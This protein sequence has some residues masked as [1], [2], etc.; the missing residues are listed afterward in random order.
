[1]SCRAQIVKRE[2]LLFGVVLL[3][4]SPFRMVLRFLIRF[5]WHWFLPS[6]FGSS[7]S[8]GVVLL[9]NFLL[10]GGAAF[11]LPPF[12]WCFG[13][14]L[15]Q[16]G[17][18]F[19]PPS[20]WW[21]NV[22]ELWIYW[23]KIINCSKRHKRRRREGGREGGAAPPEWRRARQH[24]PVRMRAQQKQREKTAQPLKK[25]WDIHP[26]GHRWT[27]TIAPHHRLHRAHCR[28]SPSSPPSP[29]GQEPSSRSTKPKEW[30]KQHH[31]H[32]AG[33]RA[34]P[35]Q[36]GRGERLHNSLFIQLNLILKLTHN[37]FTEIS[38]YSKR[39]MELDRVQR[40]SNNF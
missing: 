25:R 11:P 27:E 9:S 16:V 30:G 33:G 23:N 10:L 36:L 6:F 8:F 14:L 18:A 13:V 29:L 38:F 12:G 7:S 26:H 31:P 20:G 15:L 35:L 24:H 32:G 37:N 21:L 2:A 5:G 1:M 40:N 34:A 22:F 17:A 4:S 39:K 19:P 3:F 28:P